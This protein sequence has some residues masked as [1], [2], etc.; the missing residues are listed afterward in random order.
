MWMKCGGDRLIE[1]E[2]WGDDANGFTDLENRCED[3]LVDRRVG[4]FGAQR[5]QVHAD[6]A[7]PPWADRAVQRQGSKDLPT[8]IGAIF[9]EEEI[10]DT[11][12]RCDCCAFNSS[13][14]GLRKI[15]QN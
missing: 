11:F 10:G 8:N 5:Q 13:I 12:A 4:H 15:G 1:N 6:R 2:I 7:S 3:E 14:M 9:L